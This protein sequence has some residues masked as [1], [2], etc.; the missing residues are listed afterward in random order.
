[1]EWDEEWEH[2]GEVLQD[3][4]SRD[5][6]REVVALRRKLHKRPELAFEEI[7]LRTPV[8]RPSLLWNCSKKTMSFT[9]AKEVK[10]LRDDRSA[11]S[12]RFSRCSTTHLPRRDYPTMHPEKKMLNGHGRTGKSERRIPRRRLTAKKLRSSKSTVRGWRQFPRKNHAPMIL[13]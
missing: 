10:S 5:M 4:V 11:T 7:R 12:T 9:I 3:I 13:T 6:F 8:R 1:M 2:G